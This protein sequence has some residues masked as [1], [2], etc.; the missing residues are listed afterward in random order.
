MGPSYYSFEQGDVLFVSLD[1]V[2]YPCNE[3][4][5]ALGHTYCGDEDNPRYNCRVTETQ[6]EWLEGLI[7]ITPDD[8]LIVLNS[9]IPFVSFVD[10]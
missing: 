1:N 7:D 2:L 9:H 5:V 4:D 8:R 10:D 3:T 6:L